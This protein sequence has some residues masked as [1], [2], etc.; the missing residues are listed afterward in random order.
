MLQV[1]TFALGD[2]QTNC[3]LLSREGSS[4]CWVIDAGFSPKP[5][6]DHIRRA[7]LTPKQI[8]LTH[9][10]LDHIGGLDNFRALWRDLPILIHEAEAE[11]L[12]NPALNLSMFIGMRLIAPQATALLQH[13]Q[14]LDIAGTSFEVRH[15]PGHSPGGI[16]LYSPAERLAF[17][18]DT[19]F[20]DS[21]GRYDF[22]TSDGA[23][24]LRSIHEQ[25][26]TLPDDTRVLPGHG[27]ATTIGRERQHNPYMQMSVEELEG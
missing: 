7:G 10:H 16:T 2:W 24:L 9:A 14:V 11:F 5:M 27:P 3:Y 22:P 26:M 4:D 25:L 23:A 19:L 13:G 1:E 20:H 8:I 12:I 15:T 18:G 21:I 6:I 17:V